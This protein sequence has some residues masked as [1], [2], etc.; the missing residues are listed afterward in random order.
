[1]G[2]DRSPSGPDGIDRR[3]LMRITGIAALSAA[4]TDMLP[5]SFLLRVARAEAPGAQVPNATVHLGSVAQGAAY[6]VVKEKI[7]AALQATRDLSVIKQGELVVIKVVS[8]SPYKYPMVTH[9]WALQ[10]VLEIV[11]ERSQ[12]VRVVDQVGFEHCFYQGETKLNQA[13]KDLWKRFAPKPFISREQQVDSGLEALNR[14]GLKAVADSGGA[15][16]FTG[17]HDRDYIHVPNEDPQYGRPD[18]P[19]FAHWTPWKDIEGEQHPRGFRVN[20]YALGYGAD[21]AK[22]SRPPHM[23]SISRL[24]AHVWTGTTGPTKAYFGWLHPQDRVHSH[25]DIDPVSTNDFPGHFTGTK[26]NL[27]H[28]EMRVQ[29]ERITE[30]ALFFQ[31]YWERARANTYYANLIVALDTYSDVGPD[32]GVVPLPEGGVVGASDDV[33]ALDAVASALLMDYIRKTPEE[34][35]A[36]PA[37]ATKE[38]ESP[39]WWK[40]WAKK[41]DAY[42]NAVQELNYRATRGEWNTLFGAAPWVFQLDQKNEDPSVWALGQVDRGVQLGYANNLD[43]KLLD[44]GATLSEDQRKMLARPTAAAAGPGINEALESIGGNQ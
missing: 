44:G 20:R 8:N 25:T 34:E 22:P 10:A 33:I 35:R 27:P 43:V 28:P 40:F 42:W 24:S 21:G 18:D 6:E 9:P 1:M 19:E 4:L 17:D 23:I 14:N 5:G 2:E 11:K 32:W 36:A 16:V 29:S 37:K 13:T 12:N 26:L 15:Q 38:A 30:V 3:Q 41:S 7:R 39:P 31:R